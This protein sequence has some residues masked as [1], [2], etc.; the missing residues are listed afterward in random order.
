MDVLKTLPVVINI[1]SNWLQQN[2]EL[3]FDILLETIYDNIS[4]KAS[5]YLDI[6]SLN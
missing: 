2:D 1:Y 6:L 3:T 5:E 4:L